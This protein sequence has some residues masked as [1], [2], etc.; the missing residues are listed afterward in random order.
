MPQGIDGVHG[1]EI[2]QAVETLYNPTAQHIPDHFNYSPGYTSG[3]TFG[4]GN[5]VTL[6]KS[7]GTE[8]RHNLA[9]YYNPGYTNSQKNYGYMYTIPPAVQQNLPKG[10]ESITH[11][12][13]H[14]TY[15]T[16]HSSIHS[17]SPIAQALVSHQ[18]TQ[19]PESNPDHSALYS[20]EDYL[21]N[22]QMHNTYSESTNTSPTKTTVSFSTVNQAV[23]IPIPAP[24]PV[25]V[26]KH[27]AV[28]VPQAVPVEVP[29]PVAVHVPQ[30]YAVTIPK[31]YP[32]PVSKAVPVPV[33]VIQPYPVAH[34]VKVA[35]PQ[36]YHVTVAKPVPVKVR[37]P[38]VVKVPQPV[39]LNQGYG[40]GVAAEHSGIG[41]GS[42]SSGGYSYYTSV[43][44]GSH[45]HK[46]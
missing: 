15:P 36:P 30:P 21:N 24:Y 4:P 25:T 41:K 40:K 19:E 31:P 7:T 14:T 44:S 20:S 6:Y 34:P 43:T 11:T 37:T 17:A 42:P 8:T 46:H 3:S 23:P 13:G 2:G 12:T 5:S 18:A 27:Y 28:P 45:A 10:G 32:V 35:V 22:I 29:R 16:I 39:Y 9:S 26:N 38:V 33:P 1:Q